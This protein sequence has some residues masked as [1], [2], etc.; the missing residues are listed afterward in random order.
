MFYWELVLDFK[1]LFLDILLEIFGGGKVCL[2][3]LDINVLL[4]VNSVLVCLE[5]IFCDEKIIEWKYKFKK[6]LLIV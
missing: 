1:I 6:K 5:G 2:V 3:E 4:L